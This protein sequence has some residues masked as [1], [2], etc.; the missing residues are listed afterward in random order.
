MGTARQRAFSEPGFGGS[1]A[2]QCAFADHPGV[3][4]SEQSRGIRAL[5]IQGRQG[6]C[7]AMRGQRMLSNLGGTADIKQ[8][9]VPLW[10]INCFFILYF[11]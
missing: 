8:L 9:F 7:F 4:F 2:G 10:I 3:R 6:G 11:L 5:P 1:Q